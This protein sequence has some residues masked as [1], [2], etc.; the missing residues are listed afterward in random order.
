MSEGSSSGVSLVGLDATS[1]SGTGSKASQSLSK[2]YSPSQTSDWL[3]CPLLR[4]FKR[5]STLPG[6][7]EPHKWEPREV[8][9]NPAR[10]LG[11]VTQVGYNWVLRGAADD[12]VE[13][14]V[15]DTL[16]EGFVEQ[17]RYTLGGLTKIVLR[18]LEVLIAAN[19]FDRHKILDLDEPLTYSRPDFVSRHDTQGLGV[20]DL[21]VALRVDERYRAKRLSEYETDDQFWHYAWELGEH[22]GELVKWFRPVQLILTPRA[23]VLQDTITVTPERLNFWLSGAQQHWADMQGEDEGSRP[24]VPR[25]PNCRGGK[26]GVCG[27]YDACH[28]LN[29]DPKE[30]LMYY[31]RVAR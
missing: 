22:L 21:K 12:V 6:E 10:L 14:H 20:T 28:N 27:F 26:Y 5:H 29:R 17:P 16:Q 15:V 3:Q 13:N 1:G 18:G 8:E 23:V 7:G 19:L 11:I 30:M 31:D 24:V 2:V 4:R 25:W 9:W